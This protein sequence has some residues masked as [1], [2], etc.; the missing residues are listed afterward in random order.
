M[1]ITDEATPNKN[2]V[3]ISH[4]TKKNIKGIKINSREITKQLE[5][6]CKQ[7]ANQVALIKEK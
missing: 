5:V 6:R 2:K 4:E 7:E 3:S 1:I